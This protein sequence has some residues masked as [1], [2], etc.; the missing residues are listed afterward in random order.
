VCGPLETRGL[1]DVPKLA[2]LVGYQLHLTNLAAM[3]D[4]REALAA[5][6]TTP[7]KVTALAFIRDNTGCDQSSLGRFLS[8]NRSAAMK[9]VDRLAEPGWVERRA[10]RDRRSNGLYLTAEGRVFL[11]RVLARL[12]DA[13]AALTEGFSRDEVATLLQLLARL[14]AAAGHEFEV[15][16]GEPES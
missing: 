4:A 5:L 1:G 7:A 13:D 2:R 12:A 14:R 10:G 15:A 9:M 3:R 8:V 6:G 16:E 11:D